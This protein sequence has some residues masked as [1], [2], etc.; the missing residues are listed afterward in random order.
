MDIP[1]FDD[2]LE[3]QTRIAPYTHRTPVLT[4]S[5]LN[6]LTGAELFFK[7]EN[8]QKVGAFK[9]RGAVNAVIPCKVRCS[10]VVPMRQ[11]NEPWHMDKVTAAKRPINP[12]IVAAAD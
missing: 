3:A 9:A 4:S 11:C 7:C 10:P 2:V 5:Y 6:R 12:S 8:L 1:T